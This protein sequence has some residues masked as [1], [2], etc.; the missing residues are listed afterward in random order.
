MAFRLNIPSDI[1][2]PYEMADWVEMT[3]FVSKAS[4]IS[5]VELSNHLV[6]EITSTPQELDVPIGFIFN[7]ISRRSREGGDAYPFKIEDGIIKLKTESNLEFYKFLLLISLPKSPLR[8]RKK[9]G[10]IDEI[11]D[12]VVAEAVKNYFGYKSQVLRFAWPTSDGRPKDFQKAIEWACTNIGLPVGKDTTTRQKKDGGVDLIAWTPF[13]DKRT[14]FSVA[15]VQC[16]FQ[17]DWLPKGKDILND[18]W[19]GR[20]D[21]GRDA[22]ISLAVPFVIPRNFADWDQLKRTVSIVFDRLRI[23][24]FLS[25]AKTT[26]FAKMVKWNQKEL[27]RFA[28]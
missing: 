26:G 4:Q 12:R 28:L 17:L 16:T 11:Y 5:R 3:L 20:V 24:E 10:E 18:V 25:P 14:A 8:K 6:A 19:R 15:F 21:T 22:L 7:E 13:A 23:T 2:N 9:Y 1:D 27:E